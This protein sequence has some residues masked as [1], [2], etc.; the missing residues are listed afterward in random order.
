MLKCI[1]CRELL[2]EEL[3]FHFRPAVVYNCPQYF[4]YPCALSGLLKP[5]KGIVAAVED[6]SEQMGFHCILCSR[7]EVHPYGTGVVYVCEEHDKAWG[8]W[9]DDHPE[10]RKYI[11]PGHR[12]VRAH[13]VETFR[14][15]VEDQRR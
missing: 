11:C 5:G 6:C 7:I 2:R 10:K 15:F 14:E 4:P 3:K 13:W 9:L 8:K 1:G 12:V